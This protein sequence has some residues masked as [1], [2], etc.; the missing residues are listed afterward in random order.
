[1][2]ESTVASNFQ[3]IPNTNDSINNSGPFSSKNSIV[4][5]ILIFVVLALI[6]VNL[7]SLTG[8]AIDALND[9]LA[10][11][12]KQVSSMLG[13]SAGE[14]INNTADVAADV[15]KTGI[16]IAK[17]TSYSVGDLLKNASKGGM[18]ESQRRSLEQALKSPRCPDS[19]NCDDIRR[20]LE[21]YKKEEPEPVKTTEPTVAPISSQKA[22]AGWCYVGEFSGARGCVEMG[23]HHKCMSG[24]VFPSQSVCLKPNN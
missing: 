7:L 3:A 6:G 16:D 20:E 24:Q 9:M 15:A 11:I 2:S 14:L 21:K 17:G 12:L 5:I 1:M 23:E 8:N 22:K 18:D 13:Y 10:P 19:H 4:I